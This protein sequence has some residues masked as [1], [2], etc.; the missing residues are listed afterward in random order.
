MTECRTG[1]KMLQILGGKIKHTQTY[2]NKAK[3]WN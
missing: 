1:I 2:Q 3:E